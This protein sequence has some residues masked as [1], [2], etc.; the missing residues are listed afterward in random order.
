M[1]FGYQDQEINALP[2]SVIVEDDYYAVRNPGDG[3]IPPQERLKIW[4]P[5][6]GD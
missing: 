5:V 4:S 3:C 6:V 1:S 2:F